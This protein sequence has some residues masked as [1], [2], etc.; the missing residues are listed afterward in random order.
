LPINLTLVSQTRAWSYE[1]P[2]IEIILTILLSSVKF[3]MTFPLAV[4]QFNFGFLD[5]LLW[6]NAGGLIGI[7]FFAFLSEKVIAWWRGITW[8]KR[9]KPNKPV[10]DKRT[11]TRRNRRIVTIKQKYGLPGI[12]LF[13]PLLL[14]IPVGAFLVVR[15]Y[16]TSRVKF[17][18]LIASNL[19]WSTVY[20]AFYIFWDGLLFKQA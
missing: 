13:T 12:A 20:T 10:R 6:T 11:F 1:F 14:S 2:M 8:G 15:Y 5:T 3:A 9:R 17:T 18:W 16:R 4:L 19:F 7:Y